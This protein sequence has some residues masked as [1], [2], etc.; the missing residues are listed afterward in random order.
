MVLPRVFELVVRNAGIP[1]RDAALTP[2]SV[3]SFNS[4]LSFEVFNF[5][6]LK[7]GF[8]KI[9]PQINCYR[10]VSSAFGHHFEV[11]VCD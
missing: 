9:A 4:I 8:D 10:S 7:V 6:S 1:N 11:N 5:L 2:P 3:L